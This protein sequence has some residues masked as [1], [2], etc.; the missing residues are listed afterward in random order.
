M[1]SFDGQVTLISLREEQTSE[2]L[3]R[4]MAKREDGR[5]AEMFRSLERAS[6]R[7][8]GLWEERLEAEGIAFP[9][10]RPQ[11]RVKVVLWLIRRFGPR[12]LLSILPAMKIRGL[13]L[14][15]EGAL[16]PV[17]EDAGHG[18]EAGQES[19]HRASQGGGSLRAAVFGA[20]DG[21]LSNASL[22]L[23]VAGADPEPQVVVLA[24]VAGLLAGGFSMAAGE[25]ISV[26]TQREMLEHQIALEEEELRF[27]PEE[28][29]EELAV[30]YQAR[31]L[32]KEQARE[33]AT[34]MVSDPE[35]GL[36]T[37]ARE[38][39]G[40][41]PDSLA[42]PTAAAAASF[43]SFVS[44]AFLPLLPYLMATGAGAL[45]G[46]LL[47]TLTALLALGG[48]MSLFTGRSAVYSALRMAGIGAVAGAL[49]YSIGR[50]FD[51]TLG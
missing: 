2:L 12:R 3:Y 33:L 7:Q 5:A 30:I 8:A 17:S 26:R 27:M 4:A 14:Y 11:L 10:Y 47:I 28:E 35:H 18:D 51:V 36:R 1:S 41:D 23:G 29:I 13:S 38:E 49:T 15:R 22:I 40:L 34:R 20:N 43:V 50:L 6:A 48:A 9:P 21:L 39:L 19:W 44:G 42:S 31:G 46:T 25:Y 16:G 24:G 45:T 32:E 37:L